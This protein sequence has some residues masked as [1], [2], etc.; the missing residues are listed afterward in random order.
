MSPIATMNFNVYSFLIFVIVIFVSFFS[1]SLFVLR[2]RPRRPPTSRCRKPTKQRECL[3]RCPRRRRVWYCRHVVAVGQLGCCVSHA[4]VMSHNFEMR[5]LFFWRSPSD[6]GAFH[7]HR[8]Y[9]RSSVS[10]TEYYPLLKMNGHCAH[11]STW[12]SLARRE[13]PNA[14]RVTATRTE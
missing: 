13:P 11:Q 14:K 3:S 9:W 8:K 5:V 12:A 2:F 10:G 4:V 7:G 1:F 6:P